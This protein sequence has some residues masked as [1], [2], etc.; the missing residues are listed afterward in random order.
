MNI[1]FIGMFITMS[2]YVVIGALIS[3]GV[4][5][6]NDFYVAGRNAPSFLITGSLVASFIGVG[7]FM[8]DVGECYSG[9]FSPIMVAVGVLSVG[10]ILGSVFF[11]RYL[12]RSN[13]ITIP[14]YFGQRFDSPAM[15][16]LAT[17][18]SM[19]IMLIY[20]LSCVQGIGTLMT[21]VTG[22]DYNLCVVLAVIAFTLITIFSGAKGV[23]IT[24][25]IMFSVFS[26]ATIFGAFLIAEKAGGWTATV[27]EMATYEAVPGILAGS[28]NLEYFY[29][30][31]TENM[32]W[33]CG[34]GVAW[35]AVLMV[36]PWQSSRYLM[37][38]NEHVVVRSSILASVS[39]FVIEFLMCMAGV[40][41]NKLNPGME[42]PSEALI[43]ASMNAMPAIVG[44]IVLSGVLASGIS[45]ATTFLS[46]I[47]SNITND[48]IKIKHGKREMFF[49]R[50]VVLV[51]GVVVCLL[52][53][54]YPPEIFWITYLGATVVACS[55]LPVAI[56][57]VWSKRVT[58]TGAFWGML[59]GFIVSATMKIYT[60]V[61]KVTLP[62]YFDPFFIGL[63]AGI[64]AL[65][66]G[67]ACTKVTEREKEERE[68]LFVMPEQE[69]DPKEIKKTKMLMLCSISLGVVITVVLLVLW[70]IPYLRGLK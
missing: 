17:V 31:G 36:A 53:V 30:T 22:L 54:F 42:Q 65:V 48:I 10:Y 68:K 39:V 34:Y 51:I 49:G 44:I 2:V 1:Y 9:F 38:K 14:Q 59:V 40:F 25:T 32:I 61:M 26:V 43:W 45:S 46:L 20:S 41:T 16:K 29:P 12:R 27:T 5:N 64:L 58:K 15:H 33:A 3:R 18:T 24:D 8:G 50:L 47:G 69:Q 55:W 13:A 37:A 57:S 21:A 23:L 35:M 70:V 28:G 60:G 19:L 6:A 67:S 4:K 62:I 63:A 52:C 56:A 66:I 7:L 11:G